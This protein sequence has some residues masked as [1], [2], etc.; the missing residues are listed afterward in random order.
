MLRHTRN[1]QNRGALQPAHA[2]AVACSLALSVVSAGGHGCACMHMAQM[3]LHRM[4]PRSVESSVQSCPRDQLSTATMARDLAFHICAGTGLTAATSAPGFCASASA[5]A[6][7]RTRVVAQAYTL[8]AYEFV[9][10]LDADCLLLQVRAA[11]VPC[12]GRKRTPSA[13]LTVV[14]CFVSARGGISCRVG[15]H[16][17]W[18]IMPR[19]RKTWRARP[20]LPREAHGRD[21]VYGCVCVSRPINMSIVA[22]R[23]R[24]SRFGRVQRS[25]HAGVCARRGVRMAARWCAQQVVTRCK[26]LQPNAACCNSV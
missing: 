1:A 23:P 4:R 14:S 15:Y 25:G 9:L 17:A 5:S 20:P 13:A 21:G 2:P 3:P 10:H 19:L 6:C 18:D 7:V 16:A 26:M 11:R 22:Q 8:T 24:C 12:G